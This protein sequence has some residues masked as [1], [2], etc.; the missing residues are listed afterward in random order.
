MATALAERCGISGARHRQDEIMTE[1]V[2][3]LIIGAGIAGAGLAWALGAEAPPAHGPRIRILE[4]EE[5][6]GYHTTGRSAAMF[7]ETYGN[8]TIRALSRASRPF[9]AAPPAGFSDAPLWS[10]RAWLYIAASSQLDT[11]KAWY[12]HARTLGPMLEWLET[13]TILRLAPIL[14][15]SHAANAILEPG[16]ADL[17]VHALHQG[18]LRAA[19]RSGAEILTHARVERI[20]R[21]DAGWRVLTQDGRSMAGRVLVNAA[22]A[23]GDQVATLAGAAPVGLEPKRRTAIIFPAPA[24]QDLKDMPVVVDIDEH[25]YFKPEAG[26]LLGSPADETPSEPCDAQPEELDV[27]IAAAR[28]EEAVRFPITRIERRWAGLRTFAPDRSPVVGYDDRVDDFFWLVGQGGYGIQTAPAL[29][30]AAAA[31][32]WHRALP[33]DLRAAGVRE[34]E[35]SV[36]RLR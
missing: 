35:L 34:A 18:F 26:K 28:I 30:R 14:R 2:D 31:L 32:A 16:G 15:E 11:L 27:A 7:S 23:W 5:H 1:P 4:A 33:A 13:D 36:Q 10:A 22:G 29:S 6:P 20:E 25:F 12:E 19:R 17:D 21:S 8:D 3:F 9:F 24:D